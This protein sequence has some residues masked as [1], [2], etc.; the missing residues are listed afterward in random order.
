[1]CPELNVR[2]RCWTIKCGQLNVKNIRKVEGI[3]NSDLMWIKKIRGG[4]VP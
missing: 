1:L 2:V 3:I 4:G